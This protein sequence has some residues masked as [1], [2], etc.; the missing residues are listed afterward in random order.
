MK[1]VIANRMER[2]REGRVQ[3]TSIRM[4]LAIGVS[5]EMAVLEVLVLKTVCVSDK[6][7][8]EYSTPSNDSVIPSSDI[9]GILKSVS[10]RDLVTSDEIDDF[11][12]E[13]EN[14]L[15]V[16]ETKEKVKSRKTM[17]NSDRKESETE[18]DDY[19]RH[20]FKIPVPSEDSFVMSQEEVQKMHDKEDERT[21]KWIYMLN[22]WDTFILRRFS[23]VKSRVRKGIP[24]AVRG[25]AWYRLAHVDDMRRLFPLA[26]DLTDVEKRLDPQVAEDISRDVNRTFPYHRL[27]QEGGP[28]QGALTRVLQ[29]YAILDPAIGY[30]QGMGFLAALLLQYLQEFDAFYAL[31]SLMTRP[32]L[33]FRGMYSPGMEDTKKTLTVFS[34]LASAKFPKLWDHFEQQGVHHSMFATSWIMT[35]FVSS[36]HFDFAVR[37]WDVL[38]VEGW[39]IVYKVCLG[40][41]K[42]SQ[43]ELLSCS[44]EEAMIYFRKLPDTM[45][46][47][48]VWK[49]IWSVKL[50]QREITRCEQWIVEQE[51]Q[52]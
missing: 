16:E 34:L 8:D 15:S 29:R 21:D 51:T 49:S 45:N 5:I 50:S 26:L 20:G 17:K 43:A 33:P 12:S 44:M 23:K 48:E 41:L 10:S 19:D 7:N 47:D 30:C 11:I 27:F 38:W 6:K 32:S 40:L 9:D 35:V 36:F 4:V 42:Y 24:H 25:E 52:E 13:I 46:P 14:G 31:V 37:V 3:R 22:H 18:N 1:A 2:Q 39:K 28:G